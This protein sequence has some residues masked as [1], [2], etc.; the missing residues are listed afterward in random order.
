MSEVCKFIGWF[1]F[2]GVFVK[3]SSFDKIKQEKKKLLFDKDQKSKLAHLIPGVWYQ[4][5]YTDEK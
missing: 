1:V 4:L 5:I 2:Y 3:N